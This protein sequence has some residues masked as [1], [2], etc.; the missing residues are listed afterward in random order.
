MLLQIHDSFLHTNK[1]FRV[2]SSKHFPNSIYLPRGR[3]TDFVYSSHF[4]D[5]EAETQKWRDLPIASCGQAS[6]QAV[7]ISRLCFNPSS[8]LWFFLLLLSGVLSGFA[9]SLHATSFFSLKWGQ[10]SMRCCA[11]GSSTPYSFPA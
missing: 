3:D 11:W 10:M 6:I 7:P 1:C 9:A 8:R 2:G 4:K 5:G